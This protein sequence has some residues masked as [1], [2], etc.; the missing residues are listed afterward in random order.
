M[1]CTGECS[2][3]IW[4]VWQV[5][6]GSCVLQHLLRL[7]ERMTQQTARQERQV[8]REQ[9]IR[10]LLI[11]LVQGCAPLSLHSPRSSTTPAFPGHD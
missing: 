11:A 1:E 9:A 10:Q 6:L 2:G 7:Q 5:L 4:Q 3:S 8:H